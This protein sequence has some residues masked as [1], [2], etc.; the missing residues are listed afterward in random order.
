MKRN[1]SV[2]IFALIFL[3]NPSFVL[4][5]EVI[6]SFDTSIVASKNGTFKVTEKI[7]YDFGEAEKHGIFR[8]IP[9]VSKVG[10]LY[11]VIEIN[12]LEILRDGNQENYV[13]QGNSEKA[14]VKI[15]K[16]DK[17][18]TGPH[19]Y[20]ISY[21]VKN[22]IGSNYEDHDEIYWNITGN[23]WQ[24]PILKVSARLTTDFGVDFDKYTC[25][26]GPTG[27]TDKNCVLDNNNSLV[28]N[29]SLNPYEGIT[30]VWSFPKNTFP[31]SVLQKQSPDQPS[32]TSVKI[33]LFLAAAPALITNFI[34]APFLLA[35]YFTR[36]RKARFGPPTVNFDFP[37]DNDGKRIA[38]VE[39][40]SMDIHLVDQN[41]VIGTIFDL[42]IRKYLKIESK[43]GKKALGIFG[44]K[45]E[46][47]FTKLKEPTE[48]DSQS[49]ERILFGRLFQDGDSVK[50]DDLKEDFYETFSD[51]E[52]AV[53]DSLIQRNFYTKNPKNQRAL[54]ITGAVFSVFVGGWLL[55]A[56]MLFLA[57][58]LNG[59]TALGDEMD[60]K[61]DGLKIFL[62]NMSREHAWY[63]KNLITVEKYIP[64]AIALGFIKE[65]MDQL[66]V[67]Y[68][69]YQPT[70][71]SGNT[72][73]Y[74]AS[75]SMFSS[76]NSSITTSAPSSSSGFSGGSSGGGGGGGGGG[77][78]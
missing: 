66:K 59:R 40:G 76:F 48:K 18:I 58:K 42:A 72:S 78:W 6:R 37:K 2:L 74:L 11:R 39:A 43:K 15:G 9:L 5:Q 71:Y 21:L 44:D 8:D 1:L 73:F 69:D 65:F 36:K 51:F 22:G 55:F 70:W 29:E 26:T 4:A 56:I 27:S 3:I 12:F 67:V 68:P 54:L 13:L 61:I 50:L 7:N 17:T 14:S 28:T 32:E 20:T 64:Y 75:S 47:I 31:P 33:I 35:W 23:S 34:I 10:D 53:F 38:P 49:F 46:Y 24:V 52:K 77:S 30:G 45:E 16:V 57:F 19:L 60:W 41:D 62:K 63:A 25:Y